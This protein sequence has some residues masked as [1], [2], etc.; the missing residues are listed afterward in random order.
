MLELLNLSNIRLLDFTEYCYEIQSDL[1]F[2]WA[3]AILDTREEF[4]V[5]EYGI[6]PPDISDVYWIGGSSNI[7]DDRYD[8]TSI[9]IEWR[10]YKPN[11]R[12]VYTYLL[13]KKICFLIV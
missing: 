10:Q 2:E 11:Y 9:D 8:Y 4:F 3:T 6:A 13:L 1:G 5:L 7:E 12:G